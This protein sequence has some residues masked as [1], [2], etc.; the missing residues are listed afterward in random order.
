M[1][2]ASTFRK[3]DM[4]GTSGQGAYPSTGG[5]MRIPSVGEAGA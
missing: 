1:F 2:Y 3:M 4:E 5:Q